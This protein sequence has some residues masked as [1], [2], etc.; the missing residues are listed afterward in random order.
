MEKLAQSLFARNCSYEHV[1]YQV[2]KRVFA[3]MI[4]LFFNVSHTL[5]YFYSNMNHY[6]TQWVLYVEKINLLYKHFITYYSPEA[7]PS[8]R[9]Y[10]T[11][12]N[13]YIDYL[14]Y[15]IPYINELVINL[16]MELSNDI[17]NITYIYKTCV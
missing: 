15:T 3:D 11:N 10:V 8:L 17:D 7:F 2:Y 9:N 12:L 6:Y 13:Q 1:E 16:I 5:T 14:S 4:N